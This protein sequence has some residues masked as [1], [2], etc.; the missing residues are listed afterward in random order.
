METLLSSAFP[1]D[2]PGAAVLVMKDGKPLLRKGYGLADLELGVPVR[3][4]MVFRLGS[5]TKQFTAVGILMLVAEGKV[6]LDD[7]I[8]RFLPDFPTHDQKITVENLLTHTSGVKSYTEM[9]AWLQLWRKD[10]T[11]PELIDFFKNEPLQFHPGEKWEYDNSGYVLLGAILEKASGRSYAEFVRQRI[12]EPLGM[13]HSFYGADQPII[14]G[15][16]SGY[17]KRDAG[18][19]NAPY[20]SM[21][22][23]YAAGALLSSVDDLALWNTALDTDKLVPQALLARAWT[24]YR[25]KNGKS[26]GYGYGW[27]LWQLEGRRV[28][29]HDGGINGFATSALRLPEDHVY[30]AVLT[31]CPGKTPGPG[32]LAEKLAALA[33]GQP[34]REP[35][36][37]KV[38]TEVLDRYVGVYRIDET[39]TRTVAREDDHLVTQRSGGAKA[40]AY[41][42]SESEFFYKEIPVRIRFVRDSQGVTTGMVAIPRYGGE[43]PA[44]K[45]SNEVPKER[46]VVKLDPAAYDRFIGDYELAPTFHLIVTREG[47][48][49][50]AQATGQERAEIFAASESEFFLRVVDAQITFARDAAGNVTGLVLHQG[51][52][53]LPGRKVK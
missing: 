5:I 26:T 46:S 38:A 36:V 32:E 10:F 27:A 13:K 14:P 37:A 2:G 48:R 1:P 3:P 44:T 15:R 12:F 53:D 30:V 31:N 39:Q 47:D 23:P 43:E 45:I 40:A 42:V 52:Q 11:L 18:W 49:L 41:P 4:D 6:G 35:I 22:Q 50:F 33:I 17:E 16:V 20:L 8:T 28:V 25:L 9:P 51:G 21:T 19:V 7:E 24:P 29:E 34:L